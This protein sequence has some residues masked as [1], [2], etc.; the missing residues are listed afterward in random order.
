MAAQPRRHPDDIPRAAL[1]AIGVLLLITLAGVAL[2]RL[3]GGAQSQLP[4]SP[5]VATRE[6]RFE[7]QANGSIVIVDAR[8]GGLVQVIEPDT[9]GFLR[10]TMRALVRDRRKEGIGP[11]T[12][13]VLAA[14]ADGRL[15]IDDPSTGRS[16]D[17]ASFGTINMAVFA[18][19]LAPTPPA[20]RSEESPR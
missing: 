4:H 16:I 15:T 10:G 14:R 5:A 6:L 20:P 9:N 11:Q 7:D 17:L 3:A 8:T 13:F 12:P 19:L 2:V 18:R 1:I